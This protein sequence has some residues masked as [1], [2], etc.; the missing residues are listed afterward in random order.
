MRNCEQRSETVVEAGGALTANQFVSFIPWVL[1][2]WM[3]NASSRARNLY[4]RRL[5]KERTIPE[6]E[7]QARMRWDMPILS[8]NSKCAVSLDF[9]VVN[10]IP[11]RICGQVCYAAQ[12][13]QYY[14]KSVVKSLAVNRLIELDPDH[15]ARKM[16]DEAMGR[17]IRIAGSGEMLPEHTDL[18]SYVERFHGD[19]WGFTRR[20]DTHQILPSLMFSYDRATPPAVMEYIRNEVPTDRRAYLRRPQDPPSPLEVA[21]T[22][23]V[24]GPLTNFVNKTSLDETDCPADRDKV[25][26]C[27]QCKKCY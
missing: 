3:K 4:Q 5:D 1:S 20:V 11:T 13:R 16:V 21:V 6:D 2:P 10:C 25:G 12:G 8:G 14:R 9:P 15:A 18:L 27:W 19:W 26:G 22:F 23:P 7:I 24:H 17:N